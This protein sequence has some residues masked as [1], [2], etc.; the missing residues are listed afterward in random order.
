M[1]DQGCSGHRL[2][3]TVVKH[4]MDTRTAEQQRNRLLSP[5]SS[6]RWT[7]EQQNNTTAEQAEQGWTTKEQLQ[8]NTP[9]DL[10]SAQG[11]RGH[12]HL[13][14]FS[15]RRDEPERLDC[16]VLHTEGLPGSLPPAGEQTAREAQ[17]PES[18]LAC[19]QQPAHRYHARSRAD[20]RRMH[21][22][23]GLVDNKRVQ[24]R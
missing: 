21:C 10:A 12:V 13:S 22:P 1:P 7:T 5:P 24:V 23:V 9:S 14:M 3:S 19:W 2:C 6:T 17:Q 15:Q 20:L 16:L 18:R 11:T 4:K 8:G